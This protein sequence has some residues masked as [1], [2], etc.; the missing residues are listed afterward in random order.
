M[1]KT[2]FAPN[3]FKAVTIFSSTLVP[4]SIPNS[5]PK[6]ALTAGAILT[7]TVLDSSLI[8]SFKYI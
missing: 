2:Y 4:F 6:A 7:T 3:N 8:I 5:S 1:S